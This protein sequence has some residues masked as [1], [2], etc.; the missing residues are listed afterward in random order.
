MKPNNCPHCGL[1]TNGAVLFPNGDLRCVAC[2]EVLNPEPKPEPKPAVR[3]KASTLANFIEGTLDNMDGFTTTQ[4]ALTVDTDVDR[5]EFYVT[6]VDDKGDSH[7]YLVTVDG[8]EKP[9]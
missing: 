3:A 9:E 5:A 8:L 4:P 7:S 6:M 2:G 1:T